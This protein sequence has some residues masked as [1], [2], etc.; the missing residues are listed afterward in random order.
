MT[1][2][3]KLSKEGDFSIKELEK[4]EFYH[5]LSQLFSLKLEALK[6]LKS[7]KY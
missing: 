3:D 2:K 6:I 5:L 1:T 4:M 7:R